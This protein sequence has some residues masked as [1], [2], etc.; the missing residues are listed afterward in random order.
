MYEHYLLHKSEITWASQLRAYVCDV[1]IDRIVD[2][3]VGSG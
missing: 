3:N 2:L 1:S